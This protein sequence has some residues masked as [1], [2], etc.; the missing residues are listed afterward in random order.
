MENLILILG[1][2]YMGFCH[3]IETYLFY[4]KEMKKIE[5]NE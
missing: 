3:L 4:R 2:E 1:E 5:V